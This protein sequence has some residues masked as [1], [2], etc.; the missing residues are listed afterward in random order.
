[1]IIPLLAFAKVIE[2]GFVYRRGPDGPC[3][4]QVPLLYPCLVESAK[5]RNKTAGL[6]QLKSR[7][8]DCAVVVLKIV[9]SAE[10]LS[11][12]DFVIEAH[13]KLIG[14][15]P[16]IPRGRDRATGARTIATGREWGHVLLI[17]GL[18][19][20]VKTLSWNLVIRKY[21]RE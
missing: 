10:L 5:A 7:V 17:E 15:P 9:V 21:A 1:M 4:A 20:G 2:S 19:R 3:M 12:I 13:R 18:G 11:R 6:F 16:L 8:R 14:T